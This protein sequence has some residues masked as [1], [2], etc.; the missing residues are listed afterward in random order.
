MTVV[1]LPLGTQIL[2]VTTTLEYVND[3]YL[4]YPLQRVN[5]TCTTIGTNIQ[6]WYSSEY[7]RGV[8]DRVQLHE[9]RRSGRGRAANATIIGVTTNGAREKVIVS[10]LSLIVSTQYPV[11]TVSCGNNGH[12][13]RD[14]ITFNITG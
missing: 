1:F 2:N 14:N 8:D 4:A 11:A 6:E 10:R 12:G 13:V 9:G 3:R 5:F 7:I